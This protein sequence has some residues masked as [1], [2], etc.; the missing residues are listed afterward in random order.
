MGDVVIN[1]FLPIE[2][3]SK[4]AIALCEQSGCDCEA[5]I[6]IGSQLCD[7][8]ERV[9]TVILFKHTTGC[10]SS[11][12]FMLNKAKFDNGDEDGID[13]WHGHRRER[14]ED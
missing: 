2:A 14:E 4:V 11:Q 12:R 3:V 8:C 10:A 1:G 9:E 13:T 7:R 5:E 6:D